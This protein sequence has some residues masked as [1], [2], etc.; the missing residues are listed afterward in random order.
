MLCILVLDETED[1]CSDIFT[2][3]TARTKGPTDV[4]I[5]LPI[6]TAPNAGEELV[7]KTDKGEELI[8]TNIKEENEVNFSFVETF[9]SSS[10]EELP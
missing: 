4:D 5:S 6:I 3:K 8:L 7:L 1:V 2:L 10:Y 9:C